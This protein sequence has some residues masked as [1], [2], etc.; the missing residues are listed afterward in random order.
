MKGYLGKDL[1]QKYRTLPNL[2][3]AASA[4]PY[5]RQTVRR[6]SGARFGLYGKN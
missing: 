1:Q 3:G 2:A 6:L 5:G 4:G